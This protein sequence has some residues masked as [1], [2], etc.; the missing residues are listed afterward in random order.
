MAPSLVMLMLVAS[1]PLLAE[2]RKRFEALDFRAAVE[3]LKRATEVR[4][5]SE[6]DRT[7]AYDLLAQSLLALGQ[8]DEAVVA[9]QALLSKNPHA[10]APEASPKVRDAFVRAKEALYPKPS[11]GLS[12]LPS[13]P[14][15]WIFEWVDPW[16]LVKTLKVNERSFDASATRLLKVPASS[17]PGPVDVSALDE[18]ELLLASLRFDNAL[19][20][21][22][23]AAVQTQGVT[24]S[25]RGPARGVL[26]GLGAASL[27]ASAALLVLAFLPVHPMNASDATA[28]NQG[29]R[30]E[31]AV[32]WS[33]LG[34][35][36]ALAVAGWLVP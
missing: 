7:T 16:G 36:A 1:N 12:R 17:T 26:W 19:P 24:S 8:E 2:G 18:R 9:Y 21:A 35:G 6:A 22:P 11:V 31:A 33:A 20:S 29:R 13:A 27:V 28:L 3:V 34:V 32:G 4:E 30:I 10:R 23:V 15:T 5:Q 25:G 14:D